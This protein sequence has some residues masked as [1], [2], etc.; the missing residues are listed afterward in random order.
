MNNYHDRIMNIPTK[1]KEKYNGQYKR[2]HRDGRHA[3]AEIANEADEE[4]AELKEELEKKN[5]A[6]RKIARNIL[7]YSLQGIIPP[8]EHDQ[9]LHTGRGGV[10]T[11]NMEKEKQAF[12]F[13]CMECHQFVGEHHRC[14]QWAEVKYIPAEVIEAYNEPEI[15]ALK[16]ENEHL[17]EK[18]D[19]YYTSAATSVIKELETEIERKN[20][21]LKVAD[22]TLDR[23]GVFVKSKEKIKKPDG[24]EWFDEQRKKIKQALQGEGE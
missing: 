24:H 23:V 13:W 1:D 22:F 12:L 17:Q 15:A 20:E 2:G 10:S 21:A 8:E 19:K 14:E 18:I 3:A 16:A 9:A 11:S 5:E 6:I 4:I 7:R